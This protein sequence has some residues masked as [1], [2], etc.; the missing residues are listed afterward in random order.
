MTKRSCDSLYQDLINA[1]W[2]CTCIHSDKS[3]RDRDAALNDFRNGRKN[4]MI[5][6][7]VLG[8]GLDVRDIKVVV[9]YDFPHS[10][11]DYVHRI[12]RTGRAGAKGTAYSFFTEDNSRLSRQLIQLLEHHGQM[13]PDALQNMNGTP[14]LVFFWVLIMFH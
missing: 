14:P 4:I 2:D 3:Q 6:T 11:E 8:R 12:G 7:D 10:L 5:A 1:R 13:V 9:N